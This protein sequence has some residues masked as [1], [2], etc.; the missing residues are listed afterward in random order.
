M[1]PWLRI[2]F[3]ILGTATLVLTWMAKEFYAGRGKRAPVMSIWAGRLWGSVIGLGF[4]LAA[5]FVKFSK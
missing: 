5:A 2:W 1:P 4:L 3:T